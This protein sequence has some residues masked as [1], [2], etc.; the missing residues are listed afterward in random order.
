MAAKFCT[1]VFFICIDGVY[2]RPY[3]KENCPGCPHIPVQS[4]S[5][6]DARTLVR[7][8][9]IQFQILRFSV[10]HQCLLLLISCYYIGFTL[11]GSLSGQWSVPLSL[12]TGSEDWGCHTKQDQGIL[13]TGIDIEL[14][15]PCILQKEKTVILCVFFFSH[16]LK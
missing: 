7:S 12:M 8:V 14:K 6:N 4:V 15:K 1:N 11:T 9:Y 16:W 5:Y 13:M 2:H 3:P 10:K